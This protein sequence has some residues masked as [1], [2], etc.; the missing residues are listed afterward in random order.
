MA[1]R[2]ERRMRKTIARV[3]VA[4]LLVAGAGC[5]KDKKGGKADKPEKAEKTT[6]KVDTPPPEPEKPKLDTAEDRVA[7]YR[8][9]YGHLNAKDWDKFGTCFTDGLVSENAGMPAV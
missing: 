7:F 5:K 6:E 4:T 9:C 1:E 2:Y 3:A 8:A